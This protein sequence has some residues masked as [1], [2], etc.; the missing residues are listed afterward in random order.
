MEIDTATAVIGEDQ[1]VHIQ[2][3]YKPEGNVKSTNTQIIL[4]E[5]RK[6]TGKE[7]D[8]ALTDEEMEKQHA[9]YRYRLPVIYTAIRFLS[10]PVLINTTRKDRKP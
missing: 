4:R 6:E 7:T 3:K 5:I 10:N 2:W 9:R 1:R 8:Y